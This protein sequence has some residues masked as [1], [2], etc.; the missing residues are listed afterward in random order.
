VDNLWTLKVILRGF[1]LASGLKV[2]FWKS[3]LIR[4]NVGN[5]IMEMASTFLNCIRG[6][7]PF[8]YLGLP[9]GAN[10]RRMTTWAPMVEKIQSKLNS[11]GNK[12]IS[13]GGRL[14]LIN[15]VLILS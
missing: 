9:V 11:W 7:I 10:P 5:T 2:N 8:K 4:I 14:V 15:P 3:S 1:E 13:F 12:H 6:G